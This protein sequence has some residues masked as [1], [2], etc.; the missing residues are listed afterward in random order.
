MLDSKARN[1]Q[2]MHNVFNNIV[3][4]ANPSNVIM[5]MVD[6]KVLYKDGEY[7]I[8]KSLDEIKNSVNH[9]IKRIFSEE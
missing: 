6:G 3:N 9:S 5:T 7:Y 8:N 1:M 4:S 2:P